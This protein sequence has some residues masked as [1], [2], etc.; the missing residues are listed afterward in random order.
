MEWH[1]GTKVLFASDA[2]GMVWMWKIPSGDCKTF[3]NAGVAAT[4]CHLLPGG[5]QL[6]TGYANGS[7]K[8]WDLASATCKASISG[9]SRIRILHTP[10]CLLAWF[11][12]AVDI[13][14]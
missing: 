11:L 4:C 1:Y 5:S 6:V 3:S 7:L 12:L 8:I 13:L 9:M 10:F 2:E 14:Y